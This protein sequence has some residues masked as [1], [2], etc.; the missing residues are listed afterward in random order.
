[1]RVYIDKAN[2]SH[3]ATARECEKYEIGMRLLKRNDL[4]FT[5]SKEDIFADD[6][7]LL[8]GLNRILT[9]RG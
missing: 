1:M 9:F 3:I 4:F 7:L 8:I 5:F 6:K 2:A